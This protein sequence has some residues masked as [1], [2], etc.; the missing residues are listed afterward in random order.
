MLIGKV[1]YRRC[2]T[3][4]AKMKKWTGNSPS[5][6]SITPTS[7]RSFKTSK[8]KVK[9]SI[10]SKA[11]SSSSIK[12]WFAS[13]EMRYTPE[14]RSTK[15]TI[16]KKSS[17]YTPSLPSYSKRKKE[18]RKSKESDRRKLIKSSWL[19]RLKSKLLSSKLKSCSWRLHQSRM[20]TRLNCNRLRSSY[21]SF[22]KSM[23][24]LCKI[25]MRRRSSWSR[26]LT[27]RTHCMRSWKNRS[28]R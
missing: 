14:L 17:H 11:K 24:S 10:K 3:S 13:W 18:S 9:S 5:W 2:S 27:V 7:F 26:Y 28:L 6:G 22:K 19:S 12:T 16:S 15:S 21:I 23:L 1:R 4:N 8:G 20:D 25:K